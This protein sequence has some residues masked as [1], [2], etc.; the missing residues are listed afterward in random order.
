MGD[1]TDWPT[2]PHGKKAWFERCDIC[3]K[4][5]QIPTPKQ[6]D[7]IGM[8]AFMRPSRGDHDSM[9]DLVIHAREDGQRQYGLKCTCRAHHD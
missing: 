5:D 3:I 8:P 1:A 7:M 9:C 4:V 2:C 6:G